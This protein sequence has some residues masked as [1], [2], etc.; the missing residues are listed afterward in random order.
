MRYSSQPSSRFGFLLTIGS[1]CS[2]IFCASIFALVNNGAKSTQDDAD[3]TTNQTGGNADYRVPENVKQLMQ[4]RNYDSAIE[5][6]DSAI[7][8]ADYDSDYLWYLKGRAQTFKEDY[9]AAVTSLDQMI[10]KFPESKLLRKAKLARGAALAKKGDFLGAENAYKTE[11]EFLVSDQRRHELAT[12]CVEY[13]DSYFEPT[14]ITKKPNYAQA[15]K[16]YHQARLIGLTGESKTRTALRIAR[17]LQEQKKFPEAITEYR[18]YIKDNE[19]DSS[20]VEARYQLGACQFSANKH[21]DARRTWQDLIEL[22]GNAENN[23]DSDSPR[24]AQAAFRIS[25]TYGFPNPTNKNEYMLGE[26]SLRTFLEKFPNH[27]KAIDAELR[28]CAGVKF[29]FVDQAIEHLKKFLANETYKK[30]EK[31]SEGLFKLA[32]IY[33]AQQK[34]DLA[35]ETYTQ[36]LTN[37]P[38]QQHWSNAQVSIVECDFL[39][40]A[41]ARTEKNYDEAVKLWRTF[42]ANYPL[43]QRNPEIEYQLGMIEHEQKNWEKAIEQ[44]RLLTTKYA[45]TNQAAK[46]QLMI[47]K[48]YESDIKNIEKAIEEYKNIKGNKAQ[49]GNERVAQLTAKNFDIQTKRT[50]RSNE[51]PKI[52]LSSRNIESFEVK[53]YRIDMET[54]FRKH[55]TMGGIESLN[56]ALIDPDYQFKY[57]VPAYKKYARTTNSIALELPAELKNKNNTGAWAVT[58]SSDTLESTSLVLQSDLETTTHTTSDSILVYAQNMITGQPWPGA[59]IMI[60]DGNE[61]I[62]EEKT[63]GDGVYVGTLD[64]EKVKSGRLMVIADS[65]L[66]TNDFG[67][68][69]KIENRDMQIAYLHTDKSVYKPG[70]MVHVR[71]VL[72]SQKNGQLSVPTDANYE[73]SVVD[74]R[75]REIFRQGVTL[76]QFGVFHCNTQLSG[77]AGLGNYRLVLSDTKKSEITHAERGFVNSFKVAVYELDT[78]RVEIESDRSVYFRGEEIKGT[79]SVQYYYGA[80]VVNKTVDYKLANGETQSTVTNEKGEV[81]FTLPTRELTDGSQYTLQVSVPQLDVEGSRT[82]LIAASEYRLGVS[83]KRFVYLNEESFEVTVRAFDWM[84]KPVETPV[85]IAVLD[86][87]KLRD[88]GGNWGAREKLAGVVIQEF[89]AATDKEGVATQGI[90][91]EKGGTYSIRV[92]GTD[93]FN[94]TISEFHDIFISGDDDTARLRILV[95]QHT[96]RV[97]ETAS[98]KVHWRENKTRALMM[99]STDRISKY[100]VVDLQK[101]DN[102][103]EIPLDASLSPGFTIAFVALT[104]LRKDDQ[105]DYHFAQSEFNVKPNLNLQ[106]KIVD[107]DKRDTYKPGDEISVELTTS[108]SAGKPIT[109]ALSVALTE[110]ALLKIANVDLD[111]WDR[112][113]SGTHRSQNLG[114]SSSTFFAYIPKTRIINPDVLS[115]ERRESLRSIARNMPNRR[116]NESADDMLNAQIVRDKYWSDVVNNSVY[117]W[118]SNGQK[119]TEDNF[120]FY[121]GLV[122][123]NPDP[124]ASGFS[125]GSEWNRGDENQNSN[126]MHNSTGGDSGPG[127]LLGGALGSGNNLFGRQPAGFIGQ[128]T[129]ARGITLNS[130]QQQQAGQQLGELLNSDR[131]GK[132]LNN[133]DGDANVDMDRPVQLDVI[134]ESGTTV[135]KSV[136]EKQLQDLESTIEQYS[137]DLSLVVS[138]TQKVHSY[139]DSNEVILSKPRRTNDIAI[140][141]ENGTYN[142]VNLQYAVPNP[143]SSEMV[144]SFVTGLNNSGFALVP[145]IPVSETGYWNPSVITDENGKATVKIRLPSRSTSWQLTALGISKDTLTAHETDTLTVK[146]GLFGQMRVPTAYT[147]GDK[148][149]TRVTVHNSEIKE[150][151]ITVE[152]KTTIGDKTVTQ[153]KTISNDLVG[154]HEMVFEN[155]VAL[156]K[157][158]SVGTGANVRY[159]LR[160]TSG[161]AADLAERIIPIKPYG[162]NIYATSGGVSKASTATSVTMPEGTPFALPQLQIMVGP[163]FE[164]S[165]YDVL[166]GQSPMCQFDSQRFA[167]TVERLTAD[168]LAGIALE[169]LHKKQNPQGSPFGNSL[170][171]RNRATLSALLSLESNQA[172][173]SW[174]R[175]QQGNWNKQSPQQQRSSSSSRDALTSARALWAISTAQK[176]GYKIDKS[177]MTRAVDSVKQELGRASVSDYELKAVLLHALTTAGESDFT[178]ANQL[179]RNRNSLSVAALSYLSLTFGEMDR[180]NTAEELVK[181]LEERNVDQL[182]NQLRNGTLIDMEKVAA[183]P[184]N[185]SEAELRSLVALAIETSSRDEGAFTKQRNALLNMRRGNRWAPD[186]ATGPATMALASWQSRLKS[187]MG[188]YSLKITVNDKPFKELTVKK[189]SQTEILSVPTALL[190]E[191]AKQDIRFEIDGRGEFAYQCIFGGF[192]SADLVAESTENWNVQRSY[193]PAALEVDGRSFDRGFRVVDG[194]DIQFKNNLTELPIGE[195]GIVE[196][197]VKVP[198]PQGSDRADK[199][200]Y[201]VI[202]EPI[203]AGANVIERSITGNFERFE[204]L[205]GEILFYVGASRQ[206]NIRYQIIGVSQGNYRAGPTVVRNSFRLD[207]MAVAKARPLRILAEDQTSSDDYRMSPDELYHVGLHYKEKGKTKQ[208]TEYLTKLLEDWNVDP[209]AYKN[210]TV[211]LFEMHLNDGGSPAQTVKYFETIIEKYPGHPITFES[212]LKVAEAYH[213]IGEYERSYLVYRATLEASFGR[214]LTISGFLQDEGE[215]EKSVALIQKLISQYPPESHVATAR[216]ALTQ[217]VYQYAAQAESDEKLRTAGI[218][219]LHLID[220]AARMLDCYLMEFPNDPSADEASF[221]LANALLDLRRYDD[222]IAACAKYAERY[223]KS[224]FLDSFWYVMG[225]CYFADGTTDKAI[226]MCQKVAD[227]KRIDPETKRETESTNK[228]RAIYILG[229]IYHS[230]GQAKKAIDFYEQVKDRFADAQQAIEYFAREELKFEEVQ[231]FKPGEKANVKL[232]Y[233]NIHDC[234]ITVYK[235]D[236]MK[237][238]LLQR[239]LSNVTNINLSGIRPYHLADV[240]LKENKTYRDEDQSVELPLKNEGAYLVVCTS[241][242]LYSSGLV[243]VTPLE[244]EVNEDARSQRIR[245]TL[246]NAVENKYLDDVH[247]KAIGSG[248]S[249]FRSG[250]TDLRGVFVADGL[251]GLVTV[252]AKTDDN[253]YAFYR[254]KT[255][256]GG[257]GR[258]SQRGAN[259]SAGAGSF[260]PSSEAAP[261]VNA[262][263]GKDTLLDDL[264]GFNQRIQLDNSI[265][266]K[267]IL[268]SNE[269]KS[270]EGSFEKGG[271]G[272]GGILDGKK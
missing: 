248:N 5:A 97:G 228:W 32:S 271:F 127:A 194:N 118:A 216:Y 85:K 178:L 245:A 107:G 87:K 254:G 153:T 148:T 35:R 126:A 255:M 161:E 29:G 202:S 179:Y 177:S 176:A 198:R 10:A 64:P 263:P 150:G 82:F 39:K 57:S 267:Q 145:Q 23:K 139:F 221:S 181:V 42:M 89:E 112:Y 154:I 144:Q 65:H 266:M 94:N 104:D 99:Y 11:A 54:Y 6:I 68:I 250:E 45:G 258:P 108:D 63:N 84:N 192:V 26:T 18:D 241:D 244:I 124:I 207:Q 256:L 240:K 22:H 4:D 20:L 172:G 41:L 260:A 242:N 195:R 62:A 210:S 186:K 168:L 88:I 72:R 21:G 96:Y 13:G 149:Q 24:I 61:I 166:F 138:Q 163:N 80:P 229:Q 223:P 83:T 67:G 152:L 30:N 174:T 167:T 209:Q 206:A 114:G 106:M 213:N 125:A 188:D 224:E 8:N 66:S 146:Q 132:F 2:L 200:D 162:I 237:F 173:W 262:I 151:E 48:T 101:G 131:Q 199:L 60:S 140:L 182:L 187:P 100:E 105:S 143:N 156:P 252:I 79:I 123:T 116:G 230:M 141:S 268:Q 128:R 120:A 185:R 196:L 218:T 130:Q 109:A 113:Y 226:E 49:L 28:I 76:D 19:N 135:L 201:L 134:E 111:A 171:A 27:E 43:D 17:C 121:M 102:T 77:T 1:F 251:Q 78:V 269:G 193:Q 12:I 92:T 7:G 164:S 231:T 115:E 25:D 180:K 52:E 197:E 70:E 103:F 259:Q 133:L 155:Q 122:R 136:D 246:K 203:P 142:I 232:N 37:Y 110:E 233:R 184:A 14:D 257:T 50:F 59:H 175:G 214:E 239:N 98:V 160:V 157:D 236:L 86:M 147:D 215:F 235:I 74:N 40:A 129:N 93:R 219:R 51:T 253:Q 211:S 234:R 38:S 58:V 95:D 227:A 222:A 81:E 137:S 225:Y 212:Y 247:V 264:K 265:K 73:L 165:L 53:V 261:T 220:R 75:E 47:A 15:Y 31:R 3:N 243:L 270:N 117:G 69:T 71:G 249:D 55:Q 91:I 90:S 189:D 46:G 208:A 169:Q 238:S 205:P 217:Q 56:I 158:L 36:Y 183:L 170:H 191:G 159:E 9:D 119:L 204:I 34:F 272:G 33:F 44:W 190:N 16:F